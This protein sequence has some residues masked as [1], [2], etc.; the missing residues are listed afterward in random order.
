MV[1]HDILAN[2]IIIMQEMNAQAIGMPH[3]DSEYKKIY[4]KHA[5][6]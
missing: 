4:Y 1:R 3:V 6:D 2:I 5:A